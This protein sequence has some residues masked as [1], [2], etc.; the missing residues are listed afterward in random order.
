MNAKGFS[1]KHSNTNASDYICVKFDLEIF[2]IEYFVG[3][4]VNTITREQIFR[5]FV[6]SKYKSALTIQV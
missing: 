3:K 1:K 5:F 2:E 6:R 4:L